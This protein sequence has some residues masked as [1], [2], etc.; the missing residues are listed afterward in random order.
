MGS[1]SVQAL[2]HLRLQ[3]ILDIGFDRLPVELYRNISR[4]ICKEL[5][6]HYDKVGWSNFEKDLLFL[7]RNEGKPLVYDPSLC[8]YWIKMNNRYTVV[9]S[10]VKYLDSKV[11]YYLTLEETMGRVFELILSV[12]YNPW[13]RGQ[14]PGYCEEKESE[15]YEILDFMCLKKQDVVKDLMNHLEDGKLLDIIEPIKRFCFP[16]LCD[17]L[18]GLII[19]HKDTLNLIGIRYDEIDETP[20]VYGIQFHSKNINRV[21]AILA[22]NRDS[23]G[24][25]KKICMDGY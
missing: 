7:I 17:T 5:E 16:P 25:I 3:Q 14:T 2:R 24:S 19:L 23:Y 6:S 20:V 8:I 11:Y 13:W 10:K 1:L 21:L 22:Y 12:P 4:K 15:D 18:A 9:S